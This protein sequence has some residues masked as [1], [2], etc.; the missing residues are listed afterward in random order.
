MKKGV[1]GNERSFLTNAL[2]FF[3]M[4]SVLAALFAGCQKKP[5]ETGSRTVESVWE[6]TAGYL[7]AYDA[8][9]KTSAGKEWV[10]IGLTLAARTDDK[11]RRTYLDSVDSY[12]REKGKN[13][14]H[15]NK[16]TENSRVI[17]GIVSA[18]GDPE[19]IGGQNL[20]A[21]LAD[22]DY[23]KQQGNNGPMWALMALDAVREQK[24]TAGNGWEEAEEIAYFREE[25]ID[26]IL[27]AQKEDGGYS[28]MNGESDTDL[29]SMAV[30]ALA[31]Y[32]DRTEVKACIERALKHLSGRQKEDGTFEGYGFRTSESISQVILALTS[33]GISP[34]TDERFIKNGI[35]LT[36]ALLSFRTGSGFKH[37]LKDE[38]VNAIA[39]EQAFLALNALITVRN[40]AAMRYVRSE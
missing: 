13:R 37:V 4:V 24:R 20:I 18:G 21:G 36:D 15:E 2:L 40:G 32:R 22:I 33:L 7:D 9:E 8:Q 10:F 31:P 30:Q 29:T 16:S 14:L 17:L 34:E 25:L 1:T 35:T 5:E 38:S 26:S 19:E 12:V 3:V 39:T 23:V 27:T 11:D 6:E 28:M